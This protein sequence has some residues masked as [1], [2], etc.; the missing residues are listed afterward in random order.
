MFRSITEPDLYPVTTGMVV[1]TYD[2]GYVLDRAW[3]P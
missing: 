1:V 2:D 3:R